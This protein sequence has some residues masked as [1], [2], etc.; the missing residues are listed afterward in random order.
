MFTFMLLICQDSAYVTSSQWVR[1]RCDGAKDGYYMAP[2]L[3]QVGDR[4]MAAASPF[5]AAH[6]TLTHSGLVRSPPST[7]DWHHSTER[8]RCHQKPTRSTINI[9]L[10][11]LGDSV[12]KL[13]CYLGQGN[14]ITQSTPNRQLGMRSTFL[15]WSIAHKETHW[16]TRT[17]KWGP[18]C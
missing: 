15:K 3:S 18:L 1:E 6:F 8:E 5:K 13:W 2:N 17:H 7:W 4:T 12:P 10:Y 11:F 16:G 9:A 14:L